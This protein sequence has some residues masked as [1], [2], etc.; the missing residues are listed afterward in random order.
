[1]KKREVALQRELGK[2]QFEQEFFLQTQLHLNYWEQKKPYQV[3]GLYLLKF[4]T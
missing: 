1:M 4:I 3:F 2:I